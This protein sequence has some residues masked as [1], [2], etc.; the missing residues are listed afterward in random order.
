MPPPVPWHWSG[1][2]HYE[3]WVQ[4]CVTAWQDSVTRPAVTPRQTF[5]T[6]DTLHKLAA[7]KAY[8]AYLLVE[9]RELSARRL[10]IAFAALCWHRHGLTP[11]FEV[12]SLAHQWRREIHVSVARAVHGLQQA[13]RTLRNGVRADRQAYF[14]SLAASVQLSDH[15]NPKA[16]FAAVRRA[17]PA[18]RSA[19]RSAFRPLPRVNL[20]DGS[21]ALDQSARADRWIQHFSAQEAGEIVDSTTYVH[22]VSLQQTYGDRHGPCFDVFCLPDLGTVECLI[23]KACKGRAAGPDSITSELLQLQPAVAARSFCLCT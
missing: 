8:K 14:E 17:F 21:P 20:Q 5:L 12:A 23:L 4:T 13:G 19:K 22:R 2:H 16:L 11:S 7:K 1:D 10:K 6:A 3:A 9:E 18:A 15:R